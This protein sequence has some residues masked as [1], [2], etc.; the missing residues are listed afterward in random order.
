[1]LGRKT[2]ESVHIRRSGILQG[3]VGYSQATR[4]EVISILL[5]VGG[6]VSG[7]HS[8]AQRLANRFC[9]NVLC[10]SVSSQGCICSPTLSVDDR[11]LGSGG[12]MLVQG[13]R[14]M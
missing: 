12:D 4:R 6:C 2:E 8:I 9:M 7:H 13:E 3:K 11:T 10:S 1:M 5:S 14:E